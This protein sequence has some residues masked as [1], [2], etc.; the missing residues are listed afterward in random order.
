MISHKD[1]RP[2]NWRRFIYRRPMIYYRCEGV[3]PF[4]MMLKCL[5]DASCCKHK[6]SKE[7]CCTTTG[8]HKRVRII[9]ERHLSAIQPIFLIV[10]NLLCVHSPQRSEI[11]ST[12]IGDRGNLTSQCFSFAWNVEFICLANVLFMYF[13]YMQ[14]ITTFERWWMNW[15]ILIKQRI[16]LEET[17]FD[18]RCKRNF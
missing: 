5:R 9:N 4:T 14:P 3:Q 11:G 6:T 16:S 12:S 10:V 13:H 18:L 8:R 7:S 1:I 15:L 2:K 17:N